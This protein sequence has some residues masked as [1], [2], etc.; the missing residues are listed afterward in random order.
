MPR[1]LEPLFR[2][3]SLLLHPVVLAEV[4]VGARNRRHLQDLDK[5]LADIPLL[6]VKSKDF[7]TALDL[8]RLPSLAH[9][10]GW[11]DCLIAATALRMDVAVVTINDK[12]FRPIADL[13][14]LRPY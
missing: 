3:Q 9:S 12:H 10:T 2:D 11:A 8:V 6:I 1:F 13:R 5:S 4:L 14:V 7:H